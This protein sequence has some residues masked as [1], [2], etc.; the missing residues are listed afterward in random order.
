[1]NK[2]I[3][4]L[5]NIAH[6]MEYRDCEKNQNRE[7][8]HWARDGGLDDELD[9]L[10]QYHNNEKKQIV[11]EANRENMNIEEVLVVELNKQGEMLHEF[12]VSYQRRQNRK[13]WFPIFVGIA[14]F[15]LF[16][17]GVFPMLKFLFSGIKDADVMR[18]ALNFLP[19]DAN[20]T[21]TVSDD[22]MITSWDF[23]NRSPRFF[24]KLTSQMLTDSTLDHNMTLKD[25]TWASAVTPWYF[26][27]AIIEDQIYFS[28]DAVAQSPAMFAYY[29]ATEA[30]NQSLT[31]IRVVSVGSTNPLPENI[32]K[33]TSVASWISRVTTLTQRVKKHTQDFMLR[34]IMRRGQHNFHKFETTV[35][36]DWESALY[37]SRD[38]AEH[39]LD[40]SREMALNVEN[41]EVYEVLDGLVKE[42][43]G[44]SKPA[45]CVSPL[46]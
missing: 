4:K 26:K 10:S 15:M 14:V 41:S 6:K 1:M 44:P 7:Y 23:N 29:Y 11:A 19:E 18:E 33:G 34:T 8:L 39:L 24:T 38:R 37:W 16:F 31:D 9:H 17:Y 35:S 3:E 22:M 30:L 13:W 2:N 42:K 43:F 27:P 45:D 20:I 12:N 21:N 5:K 40:K 28:G 46:A 36:A 25:M 32:S